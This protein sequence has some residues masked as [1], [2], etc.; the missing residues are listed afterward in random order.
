MGRG[1]TGR[2]GAGVGGWKLAGV[3]LSFSYLSHTQLYSYLYHKI[4]KTFNI[5]V[6]DEKV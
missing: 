5:F 2:D 3:G 1:G 4:V 6:E